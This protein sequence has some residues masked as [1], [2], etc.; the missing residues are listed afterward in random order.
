MGG[1]R[2][3][4]AKRGVNG[5]AAEHGG[6]L[7]GNL[8]EGHHGIRVRASAM[9]ELLK[10]GESL[11][12]GK[13][14]HLPMRLDDL[15]VESRDPI[16]EGSRCRKPGGLMRPILQSLP[17]RNHSLRHRLS[18]PFCAFYTRILFLCMKNGNIL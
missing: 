8:G 13:L 5:R 11:F 16:K 9:G 1:E 17:D 7:L 3:G 2:V 6:Y 18:N 4:R 15:E 10:R 14:K 12:G